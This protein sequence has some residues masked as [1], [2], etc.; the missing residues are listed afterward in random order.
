MYIVII[1]KFCITTRT[2]KMIYEIPI[3]KCFKEEIRKNEKFYKGFDRF[4]FYRPGEFCDK[5][6]KFTN[7]TIMFSS[8][9]DF[10]KLCTYN[11]NELC[12]EKGYVFPGFCEHILKHFEETHTY[13][14][15]ILM[16]AHEKLDANYVLENFLEKMVAAAAISY[17]KD[18]IYL[19]QH[20]SVSVFV[21]NQKHIKKAFEAFDIMIKESESEFDL[22]N[23]FT[24]YKKDYKKIFQYCFENRL[25]VEVSCL[26]WYN[27]GIDYEFI[28]HLHYRKFLNIRVPSYQYIKIMNNKKTWSS[29]C[30]KLIFLQKKWVE[31]MYS[32]NSPYVKNV[33][34]TRFNKLNNKLK[35]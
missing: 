33:L 27:E 14:N 28:K 12:F 7:T 25:D 31:Y 5:N 23:N 21:K 30:S 26:N 35:E 29:K 22:F 3:C 24:C 19:I 17:F 2:Y 4:A 1:V 11:Y 6:I 32:P 8:Y 16:F 15:W 13:V 10:M 9:L 20:C 34:K 18:F